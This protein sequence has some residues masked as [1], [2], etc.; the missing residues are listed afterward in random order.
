MGNRK[1]AEGGQIAPVTNALDREI[2]DYERLADAIL[3]G[4]QPKVAVVD[5]V[6][7]MN[8]VKV[9]QSNASL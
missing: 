1:M 5:I 6:T 2:I 4:I 7:G 8:K 9:I 3:M